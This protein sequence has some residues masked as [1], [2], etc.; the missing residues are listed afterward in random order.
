MISFCYEYMWRHIFETVRLRIFGNLLYP[1]QQ[2]YFILKIVIVSL[3]VAS[4]KLMTPNNISTSKILNNKN[5]IYIFKKIFLIFYTL[6]TT[7]INNQTDKIFLLY[8][9]SIQESENEAIFN[10]NDNCLKDK[11]VLLS[12]FDSS[13]PF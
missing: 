12:R 1:E 13:Q 7:V 5:L 2:T 9:N 8:Q 3:S 4:A 11:I 10:I 6:K